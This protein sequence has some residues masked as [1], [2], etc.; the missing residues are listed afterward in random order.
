MNPLLPVEWVTAIRFLKQGRLQTVFIL[1]GIA[2]GVAVIVFMTAMLAGLEQN[3]LKRVLTST[4][5]VQ[6]LPPDQVARPLLNGAG[7]IEDPVVQRPS[8]RIIS[9]DQWRKIVEAARSMPEVARVSPTAGGSVLASR[10]DASRSA[11][12]TGVEPETYFQIVRVPD[13]VVA[14]QPRLTSEDLIVGIELARDLGAAVGI[15]GPAVYRHFSNKD[16][17]LVE[18]LV[19]IS[20]RLLAGGQQVVETTPDPR[21]ALEGLVDFHLDFALGEPDLIRVQD[22]EFASLPEDARR[23]VRRTQRLYVEIWVG[24]LCR[25]DPALPESDA[26]TM[27]HAT[28]GLINS[29]PHSAD[30]RSPESTRA[31][32]RRMALAAL[33]TTASA[34][35]PSPARTETA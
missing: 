33:T 5:H 21:D 2:I 10:G 32:L 11:T 35:A 20:R 30:P 14:G 9:I 31:V 26:R 15:S 7:V 19:D 8:Q 23:E 34:A 17:L 16:A 12:M 25:L 13:Y 1:V 29:T 27:A 3:F 24:V 18:L 22:R 6:L 28:F 4:P